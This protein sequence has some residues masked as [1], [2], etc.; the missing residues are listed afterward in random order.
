M[1]PFLKQ[2]AR[3]YFAQTDIEKYCFIFPNRRSMAF[4]R[5]YLSGAVADRSLNSGAFGHGGAVR[6]IVMPAMYTMNDFVYESTGCRETDRVSLLV[7]LYDCYVAAL[8]KAAVPDT[9]DEFIFWGDT[10]IA[11]FN[12]V[13][14]CLIKPELIFTN[15][16]QF[17]ALDTG[18]GELDERQ[19]EALRKLISHFKDEGSEELSFK[20]ADKTKENF[21]RIWDM[22]L[23]IYQ[24]FN[25]SLDSQGLSYEGMAYRKFS[26]ADIAGIFPEAE[27]F[28]FV[29]LNALSEC[30]KKAMKRLRDAHKAEFCWDFTGAML[31]DA[32]NQSSKFMHNKALTGNVD[33]FPQAFTMDPDGL[34]LPRVRVISVPSSV[35]QA[36]YIPLILN[37]IAE[38]QLE[39]TGA[40]D[41]GKDCAIVLPDETM[42][43]SVL[44]SIP[45]QVRDINV[46]MG[47]PMSDSALFSLISQVAALQTHVRKYSSGVVA[48]YHKQV[49]SI[50]SSAV[51][52][53][54]AGNEA[55]P[56]MDKIRSESKYYVPVDDFKGQPLLELVFTPVLTDV[57]QPSS[58]QIKTFGEYL[59]SV[60][61]AVASKIRGAEPS[62]DEGQAGAMALEVEFARKCYQSINLL[63]AKNL[64]ILPSTYLSLL[65]RLLGGIS[66]PFNGEPLK[67]LQVMGPLETR[68]LDFTNIIILSAGES[69]F[70]GKS[71]SASFIPPQVRA[72]FGL[73]SY[74]Y[75]DR[76]WAYYFY[77]MIERASNVWMIYDSRQDGMTSGEESRYIKQLEYI[78]HDKFGVPVERFV[79]QANVTEQSPAEIVKTREDVELLKTK[80]LS[81]SSLKSYL[82]CPAKFYF[83]VVKGLRAEEDVAESVD[84]GMVGRIYHSTMQALFSGEKDMCAGPVLGGDEKL[85]F[86]SSYYLRS[87]LGRVDEIEEKVASLMEK[88]MKTTEVSGRDLVTKRLIVK[89]VLNTIRRDLEFL[90]S[91]KA[92]GFD[93][94][95]LELERYWNF[96][97]FRFVGYID[98]LDGVK[99]QVRIVDYKT[100]RV[101][102]SEKEIT[103]ENAASVAEEIFNPDSKARPEVAFQ[104][105]IYDKLME[106]DP[107]ARKGALYN[108][109]YQV[110][111]LFKEPV[112][113]VPVCAEFVRLCEE[114]LARLLN[115]IEDP[116]TGF[117]RTS[118]LKTCEHCD[119][120][121]LCGR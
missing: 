81:A 80:S 72:G 83:S 19:R 109:I 94:Y 1:V 74:E 18:F 3:H 79:A 27:K 106:K 13:D 56:L 21:L 60:L 68:A 108:S 114:G 7:T 76:V 50:F 32:D 115:E 78:Y 110:T 5:K 2:V 98:R 62:R 6:P 92:P 45:P 101:L 61:R 104:M 36:S 102:D 88:E 48:F 111:G 97:G 28:V 66:V 53:F 59:M 54:A 25:Q 55:V 86:V 95:G 16:S 57:T 37:E 118:N 82:A 75:Q 107:I 63:T 119:F 10:L 52:R 58:A 117:A 85:K 77:R 40:L 22:L 64:N 113:S 26:A 46:T 121:E 43:M 71:V 34:S 73:P 65:K 31:R 67:G 49:S 89:Y 20:S 47:Y 9:L 29:G 105:F 93:I 100:G 4:F 38:G 112:R 17:R 23:P 91:V 33:L 39:L 69:L 12:D 90:D 11:D 44:N 8:P 103:E 14:K 120:R 84:S 87:W 42:L 30:E 51:F 96:R 41:S 116:E 70:P 24:A 35:G 15:I 99:G